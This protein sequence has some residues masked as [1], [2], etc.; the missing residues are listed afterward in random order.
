MR[1]V[2]LACDMSPQRGIAFAGAILQ[3]AARHRIE[4]QRGEGF[5]RGQAAGKGHHAGSVDNRENL[6]DRRGVQIR[7]AM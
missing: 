3:I 4:R 1:L 5:R 2:P 7:Y 6:A